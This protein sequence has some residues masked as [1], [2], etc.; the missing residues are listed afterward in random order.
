VDPWQSS[1]QYTVRKAASGEFAPR[2]AGQFIAPGE[3]S[4][5]L[6]PRSIGLTLSD[7]EPLDFVCERLEGGANRLYS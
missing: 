4:V 1:G 7:Q 2:R 3:D 6:V 5:K